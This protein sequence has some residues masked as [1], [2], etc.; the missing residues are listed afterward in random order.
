MWDWNGRHIDLNEAKYKAPLHMSDG[1]SSSFSDVQNR[2]HSP[3]RDHPVTARYW[4]VTAYATDIM[5]DLGP[6]DWAFQ[7]G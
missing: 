7:N 1:S 5:P 4:E 3:L 6:M 2:I